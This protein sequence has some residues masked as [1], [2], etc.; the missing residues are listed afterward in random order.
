MEKKHSLHPAKMPNTCKI[1][2]TKRLLRSPFPHPL[3]AAAGHGRTWG[4]GRWP[5]AAA[6]RW[7]VPAW[8]RAAPMWRRQESSSSSV[9]RGIRSLR[10]HQSVSL[11]LKM[12]T[13]KQLLA[14]TCFT[15]VNW[16]WYLTS[17]WKVRKDLSNFVRILLLS[18]RALVFDKWIYCKRN[19]VV[20]TNVTWQSFWST[21]RAPTCCCCLRRCCW[22]F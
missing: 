3:A 22:N 11:P 18:A 15:I 20:I 4:R 10:D 6:G 13:V 1:M 17:F 9:Q 7:M 2:G 14:V 12:E 19:F 21:P 5:G 16:T 8:Q